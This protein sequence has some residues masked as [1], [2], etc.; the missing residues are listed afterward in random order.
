M[1]P[2]QIT[3]SDD[4]PGDDD[5]L[6]IHSYVLENSAQDSHF[7]RPIPPEDTRFLDGSGVTEPISFDGWFTPYAGRSR[8]RLSQPN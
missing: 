8:Y 5:V 4:D 1:L 7:A 6:Q 2:F 3:V